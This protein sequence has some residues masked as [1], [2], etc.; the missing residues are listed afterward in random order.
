[1]ISNAGTGADS[2]LG[3]LRSRALGADDIRR[4]GALTDARGDSLRML[5]WAV[6]PEA[7]ITDMR[8][9]K[10]ANP[11]SWLTGPRIGRGRDPRG[12]CRSPRSP[13]L[14]APQLGFAERGVQSTCRRRT[15]QIRSARAASV[16]VSELTVPRH[17]QH[18][19]QHR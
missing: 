19:V 2:P 15:G 9:A 7:P 10:Q 14:A 8:A 16:T 5:E 17:I 12:R 11:A 6:D 4:K 18:L 3:K 13:R 1:V